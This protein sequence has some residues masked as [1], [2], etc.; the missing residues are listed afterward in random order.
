MPKSGQ[1]EASAASLLHPNKQ[2]LA[3]EV[4]VSL[5]VR[6]GPCAISAFNPEPADRRHL[7]MSTAASECSDSFR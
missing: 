6:T 7:W 1:R 4:G 3:D 2:M 5:C